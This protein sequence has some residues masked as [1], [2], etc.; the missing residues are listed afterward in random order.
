MRSGLNTEVRKLAAISALLESDHCEE[1][2]SWVDS[3]FG[4]IKA[5]GSSRTRG[6]VGEQLISGWLAAKGFNVARSTD[7]QADRIIEDKRVE[8]KF[9]TRWK[10]GG[11][12]FQQL[13]D[14]RYDFVICL[15]LSPFDASCWVLPKPVIL[16]CWHDPAIKELC[17]QHGGSKGDDTAWLSVKADDPPAWLSEHGGSLSQGL[18]RISELTGFTPN[19]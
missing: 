5:I 10:S 2:D 3:P 1:T 19:R 12:K 11:Y 4:W 17:S 18:A 7:S 15:G 8:I 16:S 13:R 6:M 9:S 14:Q